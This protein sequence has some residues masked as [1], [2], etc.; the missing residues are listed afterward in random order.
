M[1]IELLLGFVD[2]VGAV[3]LAQEI[4]GVLNHSVSQN[5]NMRFD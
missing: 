1:G 5:K 3:A 2:K 4:D